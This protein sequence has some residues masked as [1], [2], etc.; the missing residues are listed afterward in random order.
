M[1]EKDKNLNIR[2]TKADWKVLDE[3]CELYGGIDRT[4]MIRQSVRHILKTRPKFVLAP[5]EG[6]R[7]G[8]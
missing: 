6:K 8:E 5:K 3:L 4:R 2:F 1:E 7:G